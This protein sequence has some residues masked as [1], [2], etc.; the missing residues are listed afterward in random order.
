MNLLETYRHFP[1][2]YACISHLEEV[3]WGNTPRCAYCDGE[4]VGRKG[5]VNHWNRWNCHNCR[6]TFTVTSDTMFYR[7]KVPFQT[8]FLGICLLMNAKKSISSYELS[9]DL[10]MNQ[11]TAWYMLTRIRAEMA[12]QDNPILSGIIEMDETYIRGKPR[13]GRR[14]KEGENLSEDEAPKRRP[15]SQPSKE[16]D[17]LWHK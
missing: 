6:S 5:D 17:E 14:Y 4:R 10:N 15:L 3:R 2:D 11:K 1:D 12:R 16:V 8:W 13:K 7:T 9:R